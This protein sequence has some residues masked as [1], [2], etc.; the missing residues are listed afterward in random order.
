MARS[1]KPLTPIQMIVG[2]AMWLG[3][4]LIPIVFEIT[5]VRLA[6]GRTGTP[7]T[8]TVTYCT[9]TD[10]SPYCSGTFT[11]D[12]PPST[13]VT[14]TLRADSK[15]DDVFPAQLHPDGI[16][17][18][19]TDFGGRASTLAIPALGILILIPLPWALAYKYL[20]HVPGKISLSVMGA[21]AA[22]PAGITL[23][24]LAMPNF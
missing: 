5:E 2:I 4:A 12:D 24:G 11:P 3:V 9:D 21:L 18:Y 14:V 17:A 10:T 23:I 7:G 1:G 22:V 19:P 8:A 16:H 15:E 20:R 6:F 13:P